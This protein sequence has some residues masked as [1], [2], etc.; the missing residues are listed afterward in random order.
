MSYKTT[1]EIE[2]PHEKAVENFVHTIIKEADNGS[3]YGVNLSVRR[4]DMPESTES[5]EFSNDH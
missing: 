5:V 2:G 4:V 1:I 3:R